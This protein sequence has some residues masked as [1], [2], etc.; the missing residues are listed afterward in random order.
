MIP[1]RGVPFK[2]VAILGLNL[3]DFPRHESKYSYDLNQ[4]DRRR[5]DRDIREGD[6]YLFLE[7]LFSAQENLYLSYCG[8]DIKDLSDK[9]PSSVIDELLE[10]INKGDSLE[11]NLVEKKS[12]APQHIL[13]KGLD[14]VHYKEVSKE[15]PSATDFEKITVRELT[16]LFSDPYSYFAKK[17]LS[18]NYYIEDYLELQ[19]TEMFE[20]D[21]KLK[22]FQVRRFVDQKEDIDFNEYLKSVG[23]LPLSNQGNLAFK[24]IND[25]LDELDIKIKSFGFSPPIK[26][27]KYSFE[28][29]SK[30]II[31]SEE[32]LLEEGK[33]IDW[34]FS[35]KSSTAKKMLPS[36]LSY[37][38]LRANAFEV[39][40]IFINKNEAKDIRVKF[41]DIT[42]TDAVFRLNQLVEWFVVA[43]QR[44]LRFST[45]LLKTGGY[46]KFIENLANQPSFNLYSPIALNKGFYSQN[47]NEL[48]DEQEVIES[49]LF[50]IGDSLLLRKDQFN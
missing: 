26:S 44:P 23:Y 14:Q 8:R 9:I 25:E 47:L 31:E 34:T 36:W 7:T 39:D 35:A 48:F 20:L 45:A 11:T 43:Q 28:T 17:Q 29:N 30:I 19:E 3:G 15:I 1:L 18:V 27:E 38:V 6:R 46:P 22:Q 50:K 5:G 42:V 40:Y 37:L 21:N 33:L 16:N 24:K 13:S 2:T 49:L 4:I 12:L 10:Y 32:V 41:T